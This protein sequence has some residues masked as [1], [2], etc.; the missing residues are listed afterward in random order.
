MHPLETSFFNSD[1]KR[2]LIVV[3][4]SIENECTLMD[5]NNPNKFITGL[6][7]NQYSKNS[8]TLMSRN[9]RHSENGKFDKISQSV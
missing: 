4:N 7:L 1:P 3:K 6:E 9:A 5:H 2:H 8:V